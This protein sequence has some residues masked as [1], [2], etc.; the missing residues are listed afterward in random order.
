MVTEVNRDGAIV[1]RVRT[2]HSA[3]PSDKAN[4]HIHQG[5]GLLPAAVHAHKRHGDSPMSSL[6]NT[7][8]GSAATTARAVD[9]FALTVTFGVT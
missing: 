6:T 5:R 9:R 3:S 1:M 2:F 7:L 8:V 4:N